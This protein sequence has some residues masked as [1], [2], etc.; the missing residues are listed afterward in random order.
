[1]AEQKRAARR[2]RRASKKG[3]ARA[4]RAAL[5]QCPGCIGP[6]GILPLARGYFALRNSATPKRRVKA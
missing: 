6:D 4:A 1:M 5:A 3:A 2:A